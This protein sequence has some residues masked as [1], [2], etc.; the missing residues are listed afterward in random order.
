MASENAD[1]MDYEPQN[2]GESPDLRK[3]TAKFSVRLASTQSFSKNNTWRGNSTM[4]ETQRLQSTSRLSTVRQENPRMNRTYSN[5]S[6]FEQSNTSLNMT[7]TFLAQDK[8]KTKNDFYNPLA[9]SSSVANMENQKSY[10]EGLPTA[11]AKKPSLVEQIKEIYQEFKDKADKISKNNVKDIKE[12]G[13]KMRKDRKDEEGID[14]R[15]K[16][17]CSEIRGNEA[18][19]FANKWRFKKEMIHKM[20]GCI[21]NKEQALGAIQKKKFLVE[22]SQKVV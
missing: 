22:M 16:R 5:K 21:E 11:S 6:F 13:Q 8:A 15:L 4:N 1:V 2:G 12:L 18:E 9:R 3:S 19:I 17:R 10:A 14:K 7:K 20:V